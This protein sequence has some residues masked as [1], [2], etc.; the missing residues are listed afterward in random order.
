MAESQ[1]LAREYH[2]PAW[3]KS[4]KRAAGLLRKG[5][6]AALILVAAEAVIRVVLALCYFASDTAAQIN[7]LSCRPLAA[8]PAGAVPDTYDSL[9]KAQHAAIDAIYSHFHVLE[10][11]DVNRIFQLCINFRAHSFTYVMTVVPWLWAVLLVPLAALLAAWLF[12]LRAT[13]KLAQ[14]HRSS[15]DQAAK[16]RRSQLREK[17][18]LLVDVTPGTGA[19][20]GRF[21]ISYVDPQEAYGEDEPDTRSVTLLASNVEC[22]L[23]LTSP[24]TVRFTAA[25]SEDDPGN[26]A[27]L[28]AS[29]CPAGVAIAANSY[30]TPLRERLDF[31]PFNQPQPTSPS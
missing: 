13:T 25:G 7:A 22:V 26:R 3:L 31:A 6:F 15:H 8:W 5:V 24:A 16:A 18:W 20:E 28:F 14:S 23:G 2:E 4:A 12:V 27:V 21:H 11:S 30:P 1:T 29:S 10:D 17:D 9:T 19:M